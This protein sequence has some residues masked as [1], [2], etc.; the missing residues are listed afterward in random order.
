[1]VLTLVDKLCLLFDCSPLELE[2]YLKDDE[3]RPKALENIRKWNMY[4]IHLENNV[5]VICDDLTYIGPNKMMAYGGY[6]NI[7]LQQHLYVKYRV[8]LRYPFLPC[9]VHL[10]QCNQIFYPLEKIVVYEDL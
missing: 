9:I 4:T 2:K 10:D 8:H 1:M 5:P 3:H 7:T 6:L